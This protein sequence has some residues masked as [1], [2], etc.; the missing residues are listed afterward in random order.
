TCSTRRRPSSTSG[1]T[2]WR[3]D[4]ATA[5]ENRPSAS[6]RWCAG[7]VLSPNGAVFLT[8]GAINIAILNW[9]SE[10]DADVG[11]RR[12]VFATFIDDRVGVATREFIGAE[13]IMWSSD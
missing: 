5:T 4:D 3:P 1:T 12:Q 6:K 9:K 11:F 13:N 2:L 8:D 10:K 7:P